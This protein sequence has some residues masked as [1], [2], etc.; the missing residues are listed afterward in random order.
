MA[1]IRKRNGKWQARI[2]IKGQPSIEKTFSTKSDAEAWG[3]IIESEIIRGL[4]IKS[5]EA[6][7]LTLSDAL[8][9]YGEVVSAKKRSGGIE[10]YR[11]QNWK[12]SKLAKR[13]LASLKGVDFAIWRDSRLVSAKP[14]TVRLELALI[15]NLFTIAQKEWG[16]EGLTNPISS[17]RMPSV[18]NSRSRLFNENEESYLLDALNVSIHGCKNKFIKSIVLFALETAMRKGELLSLEWEHIN[19]KDRVAYL[20]TTKN[21]LSRL[22]LA[23]I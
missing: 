2:R 8:D 13:T 23:P 21:G 15:S 4:Y 20:P 16:I 14:A 17:I 1:S 18:Q 11:I 10:K 12:S 19:F 3:K 7:R 9:R 6:I 22:D 5:D